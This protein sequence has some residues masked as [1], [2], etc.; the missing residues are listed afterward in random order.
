MIVRALYAVS[1]ALEAFNSCLSRVR[2]RNT[3]LLQETLSQAD[4]AVPPNHVHAIWDGRDFALGVRC[5]T[6][7]CEKAS[8]AR[9]SNT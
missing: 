1:S 8:G 4:L 6:W 9:P 5:R 3:Q 7:P 2:G